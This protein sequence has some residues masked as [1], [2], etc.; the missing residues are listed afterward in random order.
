METNDQILT[1]TCLSPESKCNS[2]MHSVTL[3]V[4]LSLL[5]SLSC[6]SIALLF[7]INMNHHEQRVGASSRSITCYATYCN[8]CYATYIATC[9]ATYPKQ[10]ISAS[11]SVCAPLL[12]EFAHRFCDP[13]PCPSSLHHMRLQANIQGIQTVIL[14]SPWN[15]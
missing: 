3:H 2:A 14:L 10:Y 12:I 1:V 5:Q 13:D 6:S 11:G 8:I 9:Y 7:C 4:L 15:V